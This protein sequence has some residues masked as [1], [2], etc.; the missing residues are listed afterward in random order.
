M[1]RRTLEFNGNYFEQIIV[2]HLHSYYG[3]DCVVLHNK[4]LFSNYL[5]KDTQIDVILIHKKGICVIEAKNWKQWIKGEYA[6]YYWAGKSS[7]KDVMKVIS[8]LN[9]NFLH[10]RVL[11]NAIR[12]KGYNPIDFHSIICVPDGTQ[13]MSKCSEVCNLSMLTN[14]ID[15][16]LHDEQCI[17][18]SAWASILNSL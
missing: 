18:V 4:E 16:L 9:Q 7:S 10:I 6:D 14:K 12:R 13:I 8:P 2:N 11:K 3:G 17:D 1:N 15:T 5:G